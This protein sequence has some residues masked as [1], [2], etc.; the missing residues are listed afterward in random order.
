M[1]W[2]EADGIEKNEQ[3]RI[4]PIHIPIDKANG[5]A[6]LLIDKSPITDFN[7]PN[8]KV[9]RLPGKLIPLY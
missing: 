9:L 1:V 3:G 5:M 6:D 7:F 4:V 8:D 2:P